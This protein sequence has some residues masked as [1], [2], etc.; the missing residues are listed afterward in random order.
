[1]AFTDGQYHAPL[2]AKTG[3]ICEAA[4][5]GRLDVVKRL[6]QAVVDELGY[7][8]HE[9]LSEKDSLLGAQ[10]MHFAAENGHLHIIEVRR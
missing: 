10:P 1:M 2:L 3:S 8:L 7:P 5:S 6:S 4:E 9:A